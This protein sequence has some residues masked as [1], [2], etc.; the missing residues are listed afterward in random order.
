MLPLAEILSTGYGLS[1][2]STFGCVVREERRP[3]QCRKRGC[4]S[5]HILFSN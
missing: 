5:R 4:K 3:R 1:E 2:L